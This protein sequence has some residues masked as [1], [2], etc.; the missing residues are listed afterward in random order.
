ME[1]RI[2]KEILSVVRAG[3]R[4]PLVRLISDYED[5]LHSIAAQQS[6]L[7]GIAPKVKDLLNSE[8]SAESGKQIEL[9]LNCAVSGSCL[10]IVSRS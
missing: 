8:Y 3:N 5:Y 9:L 4:A 1:E 7:D 2:R 6:D 10:P